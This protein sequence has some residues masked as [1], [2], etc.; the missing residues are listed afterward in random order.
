MELKDRDLR[1]RQIVPPERLAECQAT[2]IG[3]GS[4]GRQVALQLAA[5]GVP[6]LQLIDP[7][8]VEPV[9]L[10][11]QGFPQ[12]EL[13][14]AKVHSTGGACH[15]LHPGLDLH[16]HKGRFRRSMEIGDVLFCC[17]DSIE[18]RRLIW[19]AVRNRVDFFADGRMTAEVLRVLAASDTASR[20]H[21]PTT[22]FAS[23][24]AYRGAC[25]AQSTIFTANIAA[26]L[27]VEQ[28]TRFLR[29]LPVDSDVQFNLLAMELTVGPTT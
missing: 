24:E 15:Q 26:G 13:G 12:E 16:T 2:V 20:A 29:G 11:C 10:A 4:I 3:V 14:F 17:V 9:N 18:T 27:M 21:Y 25:T 8:V 6:W 22:L 23:D 5:M 1:Q 19:Q 7:D 28:F